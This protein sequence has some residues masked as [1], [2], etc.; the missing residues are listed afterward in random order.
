MIVE[1]GNFPGDNLAIRRIRYGHNSGLFSGPDIDTMPPSLLAQHLGVLL[2]DMDGIET[3]QAYEN[4]GNLWQSLNHASLGP[5]PFRLIGPAVDNFRDTYAR[6]MTEEQKMSQA[7]LDAA[8][9][10]QERETALAESLRAYKAAIHDICSQFGT[11]VVQRKLKQFLHRVNNGMSEQFVFHH[12]YGIQSSKFH[13][14]R[15][16]SL[17][18]SG[19]GSTNIL[20]RA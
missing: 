11:K 7:R 9:T 15:S 19:S 1:P 16:K 12:S 5:Q 18:T 3:V 17:A 10:R 20:A 6:R 2:Q 13:E 8:E 4:P 14:C